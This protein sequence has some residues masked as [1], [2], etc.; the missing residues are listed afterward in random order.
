MPNSRGKTSFALYIHLPFCRK[1]CAYCD[2]ISTAGMEDEIPTYL[3]SILRE[4]KAVRERLCP[5]EAVEVTSCYLGGGTPS[6]LDEGQIE[7]LVT[8]LF[9]QGVPQDVEFTLEANPESLTPTKLTRYRALGVNRISLGVQSLSDEVLKTLGRVH[10]ARQAKNV[11]ELLREE[12]WENWNVDLMFGLPGESP[13]AFARDLDEILKFAPP[14]LS[15]YCL[16]L[17]PETPFGKLAKK[18][19][20]QLPEE[21]A[22]LEMMDILEASMSR[23]G[24]VHYETSNFAKPG[25]CCR[26]NL[27]YWR[28]GPY[29]G[30]GLGAVSYLARQGESWGTHWENPTDFRDYARMARERSWAFLKRRP[31]SREEA[32]MEVLLT[33]LRLSRGLDLDAL[34]ERFGD[35]IVDRALRVM[36]P[37]VESGW[38]ELAEGALRTTPEGGRVLDALLL[39]IISDLG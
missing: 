33:G 3:E 25:F 4:W 17:S 30:L 9:P 39:E 2:F 35:T 6:L 32:F 13:G 16:T 19:K 24:Y 26:H 27:T 37:L 12:G 18:G 5:G 22:I 31:L 28:L 23:A 14:H 20:L 21:S 8:G 29:V 38:L 34:R 7:T 36:E 11:I 15:A 10:T 1:R